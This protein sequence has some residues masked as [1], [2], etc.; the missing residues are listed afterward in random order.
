MLSSEKGN[1]GDPEL[2]HQEEPEL[3]SSQISGGHTCDAFAAC[4]GP[5]ILPLP[6]PE[7]AAVGL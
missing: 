6:P 2:S 7:V 3:R 1:Q 4:P 5:I